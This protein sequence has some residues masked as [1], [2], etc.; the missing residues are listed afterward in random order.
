[1]RHKIYYYRDGVSLSP[2]LLKYSIS[3]VD[4]L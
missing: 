3:A 4:A 2:A 1:M